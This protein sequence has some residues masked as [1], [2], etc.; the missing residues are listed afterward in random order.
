MNENQNNDGIGRRDMGWIV[1]AT[2]GMITAVLTFGKVM[3][4]NDAQSE[5]IRALTAKVNYLFIRECQRDAECM[6]KFG[7]Q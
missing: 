3:T 2:V 6:T 4:D 7:G 5:S 1:A